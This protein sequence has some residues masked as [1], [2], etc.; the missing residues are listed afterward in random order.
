MGQGVLLVLV[1]LLLLLLLIVLVLDA[2]QE[3]QLPPCCVHRSRASISVSHVGGVKGVVV[4]VGVK[5]GG[6]VGVWRWAEPYTTALAGRAWVLN[7]WRAVDW[8]E[9]GLER[10]TAL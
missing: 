8:G 6:E 2:V 7:G 9:E 10:K 5:V 1:M 3:V 4:W